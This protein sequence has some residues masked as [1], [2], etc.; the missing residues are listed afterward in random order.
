M[1]LLDAKQSNPREGG[2]SFSLKHRLLRLVWGIVWGLSGRWTPVPLH[3]WRRFLLR[4]FGAQIDR[5]AKVYPGVNVWYPPNLTMAPYAC[6]ASNVNCYCMDRIELGKY[7]LVSQGAHLC[8]GS[9]DIDNP[10]FQLFTKPIL[11]AD[12][13][14]VAAE[15]FVGP[16]VTVGE[17]AVLGA[18][19]VTFKNLAAMTVYAGNPAKPLRQRRFSGEPA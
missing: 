19:A 12:N 2:P 6:L 13:A 18:R 1:T 10:E 9:H 5:T 3:G 14:W 8:A 7:A 15:A 11:I 16:G 4:C 17:Y